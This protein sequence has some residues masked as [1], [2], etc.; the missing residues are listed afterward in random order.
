MKARM[1]LLAASLIGCTQRTRTADTAG[2]TAAT[3]GAPAS[4][5]VDTTRH[6]AAPAAPG[7]APADS[8]RITRA[9]ATNVPG[10]GAGSPLPAHDR[11]A[12]APTRSAT[13]GQVTH[14]D[15]LRGTPA[16]VGTDRFSQVVLKPAGGGRSIVLAG[17][18]ARLV[19][20]ASGAEVSVAG[21]HRAD[22]QF[23]VSSF[24]VRTV[25]GV[26]A[27][28]GTLELSGSQY[29]LVTADGRRHPV[30]SV[31]AALRAHVGERVWITGA[32][33]R[34]P[35]SFGVIGKTG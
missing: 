6:A 21:T 26:A 14:E 32:P 15:T 11:N 3:L 28:D 31:P 8:T 5:P 17:A 18:Q 34:G 16:V 13:G 29:Y 25:D 23:L 7:A 33:E 10:P 30:N 9:G 2:A 19:G 4:L 24:E 35:V 1:I 27:M 22:G 20:K 12:K